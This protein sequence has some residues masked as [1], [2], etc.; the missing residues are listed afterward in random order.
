MKNKWKFKEIYKDE[1]ARLSEAIYEAGKELCHMLKIF[2]LTLAFFAW[3]WVKAVLTLWIFVST[4]DLKD[5][6]LRLSLTDF[7]A[8]K[9]LDEPNK[10][11]EL[12]I[13]LICLFAFYICLTLILLTV[14]FYNVIFSSVI[15]NIENLYLVIL[16]QNVRKLPLSSEER[17]KLGIKTLYNWH[18]YLSK[19]YTRK[20]WDRWRVTIDIPEFV[21]DAI[22]ESTGYSIYFDCFQECNIEKTL[23][24]KA[25]IYTH[26][27]KDTEQAYKDAI[28]EL[29]SKIE[30]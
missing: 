12:A 22:K 27:D 25:I 4:E 18:L 23:K 11:N 21:Q 5:A 17:E 8:Y 6:I 29:Y 7:E 14:N 16:K 15:K 19:H 3:S 10:S 1:L 28:R 20:L 2:S 30:I 13:I 9:I 26:Y 24:N